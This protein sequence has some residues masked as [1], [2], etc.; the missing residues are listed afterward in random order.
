M[1]DTIYV[2]SDDLKK[3][4]ISAFEYWV[5]GTLFRQ[6]KRIKREEIKDIWFNAFLVDIEHNEEWSNP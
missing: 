5:L 3:K 6:R 1:L 2:Y 4:S